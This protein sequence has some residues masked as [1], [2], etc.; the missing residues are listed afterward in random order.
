M[1]ST[2]ATKIVK[3]NKFLIRGSLWSK[4]NVTAPHI[5]RTISRQL[6]KRHGRAILK[7][8]G[9]VSLSCPVQLV[10]IRNDE[11]R[12]ELDVKLLTLPLTR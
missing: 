10:Y 12:V 9:R 8:I 1:I 7:E 11:L 3:K 5:S 2:C 4:R 6:G